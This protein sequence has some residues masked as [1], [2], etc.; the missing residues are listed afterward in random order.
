MFGRMML[1]EYVINKDILPESRQLAGIT[2]KQYFKNI[3]N[4]NDLVEFLSAIA[5]YLGTL[6]NESNAFYFLHFLYTAFYTRQGYIHGTGYDLTVALTNEFKRRGGS[7]IFNNPAHKIGLDAENNVSNVQTLKKEFITS[8]IV[9]TCSPSSLIN[10]LEPEAVSDIFKEKVNRLETGWGHFCVYIVCNCPPAEL[11]FESSEYLMVA[12]EGDDCFEDDFNNESYYD[13]LTL[14]ITNYHLIN[15]KGG[16]ILQLIILDYESDW[17][18]LTDQ[19][20]KVKKD[21]VQNRI[22]NRVYKQFPKLK[23]QL[24]Y[25]ESSTPRTNHSYTSCD[26]GSAFGYKV[27][28]KTN[29][30]F[31]NKF[32]VNG[33][34]LVSG[35]TA[36]PG[37]EAAMCLGFTH[38]TLQKKE[39][40]QITY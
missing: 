10:M 12:D 38:A 31:L 30:G 17:F 8:R 20:Y 11:G 26:N 24:S 5:I 3:F 39:Y 25:V 35:W 27:L 7:I 13:K 19:D 37:Y 33:I 23:G 36:G 16:P 28:P 29:L 34:K 15:E 40:Q 6:A 9:A 4:N 21:R 22:L 2:A 1:G 32:P 14:S 18:E